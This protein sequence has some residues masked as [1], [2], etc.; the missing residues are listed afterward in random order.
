LPDNIVIIFQFLHYLLDNEINGNDDFPEIDWAEKR[1]EFIK[2][3]V[4]TWVPEFSQRIIDG[5]NNEFY[6]NLAKF[7]KRFLQIISNKI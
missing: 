7:T 1:K 4:N 2:L 6:Q 3:Y 5:T